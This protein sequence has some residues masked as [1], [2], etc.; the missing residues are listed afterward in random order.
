MTEAGVPARPPAAPTILPGPTQQ[1]P[2]GKPSMLDLND[3]G[4][5]DDTFREH[6]VDD[7]VELFAKFPESNPAAAEEWEQHGRRRQ[8]QGNTGV[9]ERGHPSALE[10][11]YVKTSDIKKAV[12]GRELDVL[13]AL[14]IQWMGSRGHIDCPYSNHGGKSDWR[15]DEQKHVAFCTCIGTQRGENK[16]HSIFDV[17]MRMASPNFEATRTQVAE[18]IG[19]TDLIKTKR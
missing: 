3:A 18:L 17:V 9:G 15:W 5:L 11:R 13:R 10:T 12:E 14:G 7:L 19:R 8:E 16:A 4:A 2:I 1:P 6:G